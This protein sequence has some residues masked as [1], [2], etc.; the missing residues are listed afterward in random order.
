MKITPL[1]IKGAC[2]IDT[3]AHQDERGAFTRFFCES[4]LGPVLEGK[5]IVQINHSLTRKQGAVRGLHFQRKPAAEAKLVRC[6]AGAVFDVCVDLRAGSP[7][8][9]QWCGVE[10]SPQDSRAVYVPEGCAHGFQVVEAGAQLLY[11][12]TGAYSPADENGIG[13]DDPRLGIVWPLPVSDLSERDRNHPRLAVDF[14][15]LTL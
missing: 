7:T 1:A 9:L 5:P 10:L 4:E 2:V 3:E 8:F 14:K 13:H 12:H 11:L 15:G 6:L